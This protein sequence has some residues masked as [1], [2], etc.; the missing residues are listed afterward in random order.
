MVSCLIGLLFGLLAF[1]FFDNFNLS[2]RW[3]LFVLAITAIGPVLAIVGYVRY[4]QRPTLRLAMV[5]FLLSGVSLLA[6]L[7]W[8]ASA[9][10]GLIH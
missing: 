10:R 9:S 2:N 7:A 5:S 1:L 4:F 3:H 6:V 8:Q